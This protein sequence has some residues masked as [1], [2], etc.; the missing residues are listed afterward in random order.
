LVALLVGALGVG[1][2]W[3]RRRR[4]HDEPEYSPADELKAKLAESRSEDEA[5][6]PV[7]ETDLDARRREVHDQARGAIDD[8]SS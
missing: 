3:R 8:L 7:L 6:K 1:A 2:F 5:E 4:K